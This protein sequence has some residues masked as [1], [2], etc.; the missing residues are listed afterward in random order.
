MPDEIMP[1]KR[2]N[3]ETVVTAIIDIFP[4]LTLEEKAYA[5][6]TLEKFDN[7]RIITLMIQSMKDPDWHIAVKAIEIAAVYAPQEAFPEIA[8]YSHVLNDEVRSSARMNFMSM[9]NSVA[10]TTLSWMATAPEKETR[11]LYFEALN[12]YENPALIGQYLIGL[13]DSD[14]DVRYAAARFFVAN[15]DSRALSVL[16]SLLDKSGRD[17][18]T[19]AEALGEFDDKGALEALL[20]A[21]RKS[22]NTSNTTLDF[23][24]R[25]A[26]LQSLEL[27]GNT[28]LIAPV[29]I[30]YLERMPD[31]PIAMRF[32]QTLGNLKNPRATPVL[33]K[34]VRENHAYADDALY[35]LGA[36]GDPQSL[37]EIKQIIYDRGKPH[38]RRLVAMFALNMMAPEMIY[39]AIERCEELRPELP[40]YIR[41]YSGQKKNIARAAGRSPALYRDLLMSMDSAQQF[42][43]TLKVVGSLL[44]DPD[45]DIVKGAILMLRAS[46]DP[47]AVP[48]LQKLLKTDDH[49]LRDLILEAVASITANVKKPVKSE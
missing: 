22:V 35:V 37:D 13:N 32:I 14:E 41:I 46:K 7:H 34:Y 29:V 26:A 11:K 19:A 21:L 48:V 45:P 49:S 25:Q 8:K 18:V 4:K 40:N 27:M 28:D 24:I 47:L 30:E 44:T 9:P 42:E 33:L 31:A 5:L 12:R 2:M 36:L 39:D 23:Q 17:A 3:N 1:H 16:I 43:F 10:L 20:N 15:P 38:R 6:E